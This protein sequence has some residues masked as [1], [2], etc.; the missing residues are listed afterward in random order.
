VVLIGRSCCYNSSHPANYETRSTRKKFCEVLAE[1]ERPVQLSSG[2]YHKLV[3][4]AEESRGECMCL[5]HLRYQCCGGK[6]GPTKE[7]SPW[8]GDDNAGSAAG[9]RVAI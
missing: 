7:N 5:L 9:E 3:S 8:L 2:R 1:R 6:P 4:Y